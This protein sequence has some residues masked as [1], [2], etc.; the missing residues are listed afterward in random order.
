MAILTV[1]SASQYKTISAA[2]LSSQS[3][4]TINVSSGTYTNDFLNINHSLNLVALG[5]VVNL[6][7]TVQPPNGK[8][9]IDEG[10]AG[11]SVGITGFD[12]SGVTVA[13]QNG[14][15]VR[16]E[17]GMLT[18][19]NDT[20]HNNQDGLLA[21][22][23]SNGVITINGSKF[24]ANG[25]GDGYSHNIYVNHIASLTVSSSTI[26]G[27]LV[28]HDIKSRAASTT[29]I[30]NVITDGSN[31]TASYEIDLP[32]G[33]VADIE[34]NFIQKGV[35]AQNPIAISYG[36]E[37]NLQTTSSLKVAGNVVINDSPSPSSTALKNASGI[38]AD[39][40]NNSLFGW[41]TVSSGQVNV[42]ATTTL[43]TEPTNAVAPVPTPPA[44]TSP[45]TL[46]L[47]VSE[48]AWNGDAQFKVSVDGVDVGSTFTATS[49]H[50]AGASQQIAI[51][52]NWGANAHSVSAN[53]INDAY[54][55]SSTTDRNLYVN[56]VNYDGRDV[57][58]S[59]ATF[60]WNETKTFNLT[61]PVTSDTLILNVAED[62][63]QGDAQ[64]KV[65]VD[66]VDVGATFTATA[67]HATGATQQIAIAGN[68][69]ANARTVSAS[70]IND[71]YGGTAATDR[72]LYVN[73][74]NY[75]GH[76]ISN[77]S[78]IF[79]ANDTKTFNLTPPVTSD[80]LILNVAEDAWQGDA[81][82]KVSVDGVDVGATFTATASHATGATQQ[83]A[84][85]G[86]WGASAHSV[87]AS[88]I[89]DAYGGNAAADRNLY[90]NSVNYN[91]HDIS[92]SSATFLWN[93][94]KTFNLAAPAP[95]FITLHLA[96]DAYL[97]DAQYS[98]AIDGKQA[99]P[100]GTVTA[101]NGSGHTLDVSIASAVASG[102]H[103]LALSFL[104][105]AYGGSPD[106]DRNLY[107]KGMEV[108]GTPVSGA[109]FTLLSEGAHHVS[110]FV[111]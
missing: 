101:I 13:D 10:G 70:F 52:G 104:N 4:D 76:D 36:E 105:D 108:A 96:E 89:N 9:Y 78:A 111:P 39:M 49:S 7:A 50:A 5:G 23:D 11:V 58:N 63:W 20:I 64:F 46:I 77:T 34:N 80:T 93:D 1:G 106:A 57:D 99:A 110:F 65:S 66:G 94:T 97:G 69:G 37:G 33:G 90:V 59:S 48:D 41:K 82:F 38:V 22:S 35:N 88:F 6:V 55:G 62:A 81:Q 72:N 100:N 109:S 98:V 42:S 12:I 54:G 79:L 17:G 95:T 61:P 47:T 107:S 83:I 31:G 103:D 56:G 3:G 75:D 24:Y 74:V 15:A 25:A 21:N 26:T 73:G 91:G 86:N 71:A 18:L 27:A 67:S 16:Y 28:G 102:W 2:V 87:S 32:N 29:I 43:I 53:F 92:D 8:G 44:P 19:N 45:D 14:A 40:S 51:A 85:A 84:I 30:G 68:W 60:L